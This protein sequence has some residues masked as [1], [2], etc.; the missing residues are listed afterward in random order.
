MQLYESRPE[1]DGGRLLLAL[2]LRVGKVHDLDR[3]MKCTRLQSSDTF[4]AIERIHL[5]AYTDD[6]SCFNNTFNAGR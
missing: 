2:T 3:D 1:A 4:S 5:Y 6:N